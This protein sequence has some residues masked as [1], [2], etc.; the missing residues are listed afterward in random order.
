MGAS[1]FIGKPYLTDDIGAAIRKALSQQK[2][3]RTG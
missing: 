3:E 2:R 1:A